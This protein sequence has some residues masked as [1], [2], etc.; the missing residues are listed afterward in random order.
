MDFV[1]Y[2]QILLCYF[3]GSLCNAKKK[4]YAIVRRK[5]TKQKTKHEKNAKND[6]WMKVYHGK[7]HTEL[8]L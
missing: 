1:M 4:N 5:P 7:V 3:V 6:W 2:K 8:F